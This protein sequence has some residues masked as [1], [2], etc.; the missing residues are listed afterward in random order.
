MRQASSR[1]SIKLGLAA[2]ALG[3]PALAQENAILAAQ[4]FAQNCFS[5]YLTAAKARE[6]LGATGARHDFY[7]LDPFSNAAPSPAFGLRPATRGTDRRCEVSFDGDHAVLAVEMARNALQAEGILRD[8]PT[9]DTHKATAG[10]ELLAAR[11]LNPKR[12][13]VVRVGTRQGPNGI[14]TFMNVER[15]TPA[16][17]QLN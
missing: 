17:S 14:E 4:A 13:A 8:A 6:V 2:M 9:P 12:I 3:A 5:P 1:C 10:T 11:Y 16:A 15:L 7:D